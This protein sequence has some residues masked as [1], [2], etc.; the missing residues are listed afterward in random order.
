MGRA[1]VDD[2]PGTGNAPIALRSP[3]PGVA[4]WWASLAASDDEFAQ[5][6]SWLAPQEHARA[7]RFGREPLRRRYVVG[8]ASL[9]WALGRMLDLAPAEVPIVRGARGRPGLGIDA[10]LD[11]NISHTE[12]VALIG[13]ARSGR[14]ASSPL[15]ARGWRVFRSTRALVG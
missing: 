5:L 1:S 14:I 12:G 13:A 6:S 2:F 7:A 4:L 15:S 11:F 9:R 3:A 8:R 10:R